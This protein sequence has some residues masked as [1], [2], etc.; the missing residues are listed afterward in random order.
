LTKDLLSSRFLLTHD[1]LITSYNAIIPISYFIYKYNLKGIGEEQNK[2]TAQLQ[3]SI[4]EW[5]ITS[6]LTGVFGG[7]SDGILYKAKKAI[8]ESSKINYFPKSELFT[9]F[10]EAKPALV[11]EVTK[12]LISKVTY[13]SKESFLVLSLLYNHSINFTPLTFDNLPQQDHIISQSELKKAKVHMEKI[14]SI[15][16]LRYVTSS[17]NREKSD[18][19]FMSWNKRLGNGVLD[20]HYI[21]HG[22]W[23]AKNFDDFLE[24]RKEQFLKQIGIK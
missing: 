23:D 24:K 14:N 10:N 22:D 16:N 9:K 21:P 7:Q 11:L 17:D 8:G 2:I 15:Y 1:K 19:T 20:N 12:E 5:L 18:E 3:T 6:M 13:N 4:R